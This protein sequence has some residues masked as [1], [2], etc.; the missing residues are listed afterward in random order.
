MNIISPKIRTDFQEYLVSYSDLRQIGTLFSNH[1]IDPKELP[2]LSLP[3]SVR[4]AMVLKYYAGVEWDNPK[5]Y[6]KVLNVY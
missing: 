4:R 2:P 5:S 1:D 6:R 3:S